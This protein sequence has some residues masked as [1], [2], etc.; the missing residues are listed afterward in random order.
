MVFKTINLDYITI[1][2]G[3]DRKGGKQKLLQY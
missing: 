2:V 3:V 1:C